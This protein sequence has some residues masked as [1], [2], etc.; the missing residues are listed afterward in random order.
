MTLEP[1]STK[2]GDRAAPYRAIRTVQETP[3]LNDHMWAKIPS[4]PADMFFLDL[5]DSVPPA[6]KQE[7]RER[8]IGY[9]DDPTYFD[10]RL[11]LARPNH[12]ST[13]WGHDDVVAMAEHG[14]T[15]LA[16][17]KI[18]RTEELLEVIEL[19]ERYGASPDIFAIV[20]TS[21]SIMDLKELARIDNVVA[22]MSGPGDLS[23]DMAVQLMGDDGRLNAIFD[24]TKA[25]TVIAAAANRLACTDVV[26]MPDY[27]D[28]EE[29]RRRAEASR[30]M[31]FTALSTLYPPHVAIAN[32]VFTP[33]AK[34][35]A[36][37]QEL[38]DIYR[39]VLSEGRPAALTD[40]GE[41]ILVHDYEKALSLLE[42]ASILRL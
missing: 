34:E 26:Y 17:P 8:A 25:M 37:A 30:A 31:G 11:T 38:V 12:L 14:V 1:A 41:I 4:I 32:E 16:Y 40:D 20:E 36:K 10:G 9:L 7:A 24:V 27:R 29:F 22:M 35:V 28:L 13:P 23:V 5:E 21:G 3:I 33:T 19:L 18:H 6:R 2:T 15:C 42:K 39:T